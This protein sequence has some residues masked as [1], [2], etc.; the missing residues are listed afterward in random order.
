MYSPVVL[1]IGIECSHELAALTA[2]LTSFMYKVV[3]ILVAFVP[4]I[5]IMSVAFSLDL[6]LF[7]FVTSLSILVLLLQLVSAPGL[8]SLFCTRTVLDRDAFITLY[9]ALTTLAFQLFEFRVMKT[10]G[11]FLSV[12]WRALRSVKILLIVFAYI[13]CAY[14]VVF[15][16]IQYLACEGDKCPKLP[17]D[18]SAAFLTI[19]STYFMTVGS[20]FFF[21]RY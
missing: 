7:Y 12:L 10:V 3:E 11:S 8:I 19:T 5:A 4:S 21:F 2:N 18:N 20:W 13:I 17:D 14:G 6:D 15:F 9:Y 1:S 16:Y